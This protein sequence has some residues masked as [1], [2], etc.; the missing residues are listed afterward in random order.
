MSI[1]W[2]CIQ[3]KF[4]QIL[5]FRCQWYFSL[6]KSN[7]F[8]HAITNGNYNNNIIVLQH[9]TFTIIP[10]W[11]TTNRLC[12]SGFSNWFQSCFHWCHISYALVAIF[13]I[14]KKKEY[15]CVLSWHHIRSIFF[16]VRN[17]ISKTHGW[18]KMV[19]KWKLYI[20]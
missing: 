17:L 1:M 15:F 14:L 13:C 6:K 12:F 7:I 19:W 5:G 9:K 11:A 3:N 20:I 8:Y 10:L 18:I 4:N 16:F 2:K